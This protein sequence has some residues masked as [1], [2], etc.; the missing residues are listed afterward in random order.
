MKKGFCLKFDNGNYNSTINPIYNIETSEAFT[1]LMNEYSKFN[2]GNE[3]LYDKTDLKLAIPRAYDIE[4]FSL[5][6][7]RNYQVIY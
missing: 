7:F 1:E 6:N 5:P 4:N 2:K 3:T